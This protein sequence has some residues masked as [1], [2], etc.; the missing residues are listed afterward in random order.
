[1]KKKLMKGFTLIELLVVITIIGVLGALLL[2]AV[3]GAQEKANI[4]VCA[5]NLKNIGIAVQ[6]YYSSKGRNRHY[7]GLTD[8]SLNKI[9]GANLQ[10]STA[11]QRFIEC[12]YVGRSP[13]LK[14][15]ELLICPS[16]PDEIPN[17]YKASDR[18]GIT[19]KT[20]RGFNINKSP[21]LFRNTEGGYRLR[22]GSDA[23]DTPIACDRQLNHEGFNIVYLDGHVEFSD[24]DAHRLG[25][26]YATEDDGHA[27]L[28]TGE[29]GDELLVE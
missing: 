16:N 28:L 25:F 19:D 1:M 5:N 9:L 7:P 29:G 14:T 26:Q 15:T 18:E 6:S 2:P 3:F 13:V 12:M 24:L 17:E 27:P 4:S 10:S 11:G 8:P 23:T 20:K 21:Y 22:S